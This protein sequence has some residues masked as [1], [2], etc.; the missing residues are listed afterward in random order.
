[1]L[2]VGG[3]VLLCFLAGFFARTVLARKIVNRL[4]TAVLSNVPGYEFLKRMGESTLGVEKD[5]GYPVVLVRFDD[6]AQI[7][8]QIEVLE[9][10]RVAV[11]VPGVPNANAGEV[12]IINST[13]VSLLEVPAARAL[14]CLKQLGVG[15]GALVRG[16]DLSA[17]AAKPTP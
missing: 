12:Y 10:G 14:K 6:A 13:R 3:I 4:E 11:F 5:G 1:L 9:N 15:T 8:F 2:A 16:S 17:A 7:G